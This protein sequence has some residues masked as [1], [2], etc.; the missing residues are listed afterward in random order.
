[1]INAKELKEILT[2]ELAPESKVLLLGMISD[3]GVDL[4][5]NVVGNRY[6]LIPAEIHVGSIELKSKRIV[7]QES[8]AGTLTVLREVVKYGSSSSVP[9]GGPKRSKRASSVNKKNSKKDKK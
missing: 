8:S 4:D 6:A 5:A 3:G 1:M 9:C 7:A 2:M